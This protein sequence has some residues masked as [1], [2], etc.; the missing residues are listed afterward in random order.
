MENIR[1]IWFYNKKIWNLKNC[2]MY[3][4][5]IL[6]WL[7]PFLFLFFPIV[8]ILIYFNT[9]NEDTTIFKLIYWYSIISMIFISII[10]FLIEKWK[11]IKIEFHKKKKTYYLSLIIN[12]FILIIIHALI[13]FLY[14][15]LLNYKET[16]TI[17]ISNNFYI[18]WLFLIFIII[19]ISLNFK[20]FISIIFMIFCFILIFVLVQNIENTILFDYYHKSILLIELIII[21]L[22]IY[23]SLIKI[24]IKEK[25][26]N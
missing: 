20:I 9:Y 21:S 15:F 12:L 16:K 7:I 1:Q 10:I 6:I 2:L 3:L 14:R 5:I 17:N 22:L 13:L 25:Q 4:S 8:N 26:L 23:Y 11:K 24:Y 19:L 18:Y